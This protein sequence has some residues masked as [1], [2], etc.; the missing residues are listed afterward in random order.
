[1]L[2]S[3][4]MLD[5]IKHIVDDFS[6]H[7]QFA[8]GWTFRR[9]GESPVD[10]SSHGCSPHVH[11]AKRLWA[12]RLWGRCL[13]WGE[14]SMGRNVHTWGELSV[15]QKVYKPMMTILGRHCISASCIQHSPT[16]PVQNSQL[17]FC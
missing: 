4:Q 2:L 3:Q 16:A 8:H 6:S 11:G 7:G 12:N 17:P 9:M 13:V 14:T 1:M 5:A 15:G 10:V